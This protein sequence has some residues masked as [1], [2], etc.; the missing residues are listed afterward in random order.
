MDIAKS[1]RLALADINERQPWLASRLGVTR[2][3]VNRMANGAIVPGGRKIEEIAE[4]FGMT[5]SE[6]IALGEK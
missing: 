1:I 4:V 6:F 2:A 3:H 5:V